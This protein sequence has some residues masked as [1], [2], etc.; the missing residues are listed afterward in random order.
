MPTTTT[1][2]TTEQP[3]SPLSNEI[4]LGFVFS[5]GCATILAIIGNFHESTSTQQSTPEMFRL[6]NALVT[7]ALGFF[8][9]R[10]SA[11]AQQRFGSSTGAQ[12]G[13][14]DPPPA[15]PNP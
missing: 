8:A 6:S 4:F 13:V 12:P 7:G 14:A 9:G 3:R 5:I 10:A 15:P 11:W 1:T 2:T